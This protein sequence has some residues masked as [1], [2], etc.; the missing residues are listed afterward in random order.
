MDLPADLPDHLQPRLL[1]FLSVDVVGSTALKQ[2]DRHLVAAASAPEVPMSD[3]DRR[4][5][6]NWLA[7]FEV[8]Y[9]RVAEGAGKHWRNLVEEYDES[10]RDEYAG[11]CPIFWKTNGDEVLYCKLLTN[12]RQ[13]HFVIE[14]WKRTIHSV[15]NSLDQ[16]KGLLKEAGLEPL[17]IKATLWTAGFPRRNKRLQSAYGLETRVDGFPPANA[18][19]TPPADEAGFEGG[20]ADARPRERYDFIG[21]GIDIG[22]RISTLSSTQK[23]VVSLDVAYILAKAP[24]KSGTGVKREPL[25]YDGRIPLKGVFEGKR[26][27]IFWLNI[28]RAG[29]FDEREVAIQNP[30]TPD[31][32]SDIC[33]EY[34]K[35]YKNYTHA[36][37]IFNDPSKMVHAVPQRFTDWLERAHKEYQQQRA[38]QALASESVKNIGEIVDD[39]GSGS[40]SKVVARVTS[41]LAKKTQSITGK[42]GGD[43]G[44]GSQKSAP[45]PP[46]PRPPRSNP[47]R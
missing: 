28:S 32:V 18:P 6:V 5:E 47:R 19:A 2:P 35:R 21:P 4:L 20:L 25:Y 24:Y 44:E 1:I 8:F 37:F 38:T 33:E 34:Y 22:F 7:I 40:R 23:M 16:Y 46:Q 15:R 36:P 27:P 31:N 39:M 42:A 26:Y 29:T 14:W 3:S 11:P 13:I 45:P 17:D 9:A 12:S 43:S 41:E 10:E 30:I